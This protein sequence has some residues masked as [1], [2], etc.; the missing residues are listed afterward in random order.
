MLLLSTHYISKIQGYIWTNSDTTFINTW[1]ISMA[2][3]NININNNTVLTRALN[4]CI[5]CDIFTS[6]VMRSHYY[7]ISLQNKNIIIGNNAMISLIFHWFSSDLDVRLEWQ[8][9]SSL[10]K[11]QSNVFF[12]HELPGACTW[13][14]ATLDWPRAVSSQHPPCFNSAKFCYNFTIFITVYH[15]IDTRPASYLIGWGVKS[16]FWA[17]VSLSSSLLYVSFDILCPTTYAI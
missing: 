6:T 17:H 7:I 2:W 16:H 3:G 1:S 15:A 12:T 5:V 13:A 10:L 9:F 11:K 8:I 14:S 4:L